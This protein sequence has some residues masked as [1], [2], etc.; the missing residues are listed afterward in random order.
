M[1]ILLLLGRKGGQKTAATAVDVTAGDSCSISASRYDPIAKKTTRSAAH[2]SRSC[3]SYCR[4]SPRN[5][6][7][8]TVPVKMKSSAIR[9]TFSFFLGFGILGFRPVQRLWAVGT[10]Y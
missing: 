2:S 4:F 1:S 9:F 5:L 6:D 3:V 10:S 8:Y 7:I